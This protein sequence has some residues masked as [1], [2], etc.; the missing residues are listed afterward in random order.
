MLLAGCVNPVSQGTTTDI[1][2]LTVTIDQASSRS[3][4]AS[5]AEISS[6]TLSGEGPGGAGFGPVTVIPGQ[7]FTQDV[8]A[9]NWTLSAQ[10]LN[11]QGQTIV[12]GSTALMVSADTTNNASILCQPIAGTGSLS[13]Q[14]SWPSDL[15]A[16]PEIQATLTPAGS[17]AQALAFTISGTS[18]SFDNAAIAS[19]FYTLCLSLKDSSTAPA[20]VWWGITETVRVYAGQTTAG[21]WGLTLASLTG[22][23]APGPVQSVTLNKQNTVLLVGASE[24][25]SASIL[26]TNAANKQVSWT[27]SDPAVATVSDTGLVSGV[28]AGSATITVTTQDGNKQETCVVSVSST[29]VPVT[30]ISL[31]KTTTSITIDLTEQLDAS[32]TP[33]NATNQNTSWSS[34]N[35]AVATV[36]TGGLVTAV[37]AGSAIITVTSQDGNFTAE[38]TV[39]VV[40]LI[41]QGGLKVNIGA[42]LQSPLSVYLYGYKSNLA[43]GG[44]MTVNAY[45]G[46]MPGS[47][48]AWYLDGQ[49]LAGATSSSLTF[50]SSLDSGFHRLSVV[51]SDSSGK[52]GS[53]SIQFSVGKPVQFSKVVTGTPT[54][55]L[56]SDGSLWKFGNMM[57]S[58]PQIACQVKDMACKGGSDTSAILFNDGTLSVNDGYD[59]T[60]NKTIQ[61]TM[62]NVAA[63]VE[64]SAGGM[65]IKSDGS[66]WA[67]GDNMNGQLGD[68]TMNRRMVPV[69]ILPSGA[70]TAALAADHSLILMN[71]GSVYATGANGSG[72]LGNSTWTSTQTPVLVMADVKAV[73]A[74]YAASYF[75]KTDGSLWACGNNPYGQLGTG[76]TVSQPSPIQVMSGVAAI[77]AGEGFALFLKNDG[78]LWACGYNYYG[79]LGTGNFDNA[80][81]PVQVLSDVASI[82]AS[83]SNSAAIKTDGSLYTWGYNMNGQLGDGTT[84]SRNAPAKVYLP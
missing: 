29:S 47:G 77:A 62:G 8:S 32:F 21:Q 59:Y 58:G 35:P 9:G 66:L 63:V 12:Q 72:Q 7:N 48:N 45:N 64:N 16:T 4:N 5:G 49:L 76:N 23:A 51:V 83:G 54:L 27:S 14:L 22:S 69:Q 84:A 25:L 70:R 37:S 79:Q 26:P 60:A 56:R 55:A 81:T 82:S 28:S 41:A 36:G 1:G 67:W 46:M 40:Q 13:L 2:N 78:T 74:S 39:T 52:S 44:S 10:G 42:D 75:L 50:G 53:A 34:S 33:A 20:K 38:C 19:G 71:D 73:A 68:G 3:L 18:A 6:F 31:N 24:Q 30:G 65:A 11:S 15:I 17:S 61:F 57:M 43:P 80:T